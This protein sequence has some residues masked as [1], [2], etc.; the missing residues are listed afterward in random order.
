MCKRKKGPQYQISPKQQTL[1]QVYDKATKF[2]IDDKRQT[3][4][5]HLVAKMVCVDGQPLNL[6][7]NRG[8]KE[9]IEHLEPRFTMPTR[10]TL[11]NV[12]VP[13]MY[14]S[15]V[16]SVEVQLQDAEF[17]AVTT[18]LWTSVANT[19]FLSVTAHYVTKEFVLH[20]VC[21]EVIPF[22][23][24]SHTA[25]NISKFITSLL[26]KWG[27]LQKV[28]AIVRDNA[29]NLVAGLELSPFQHT[30]CLAHTLQL[31]L[32]EGFLNNKI[33]N[34]LVSSSKKIVGHFK[35]SARA[36]KV[37]KT[38]QITAGVVQHRLIHDEPT[39]WNTTLHMFKR[40][41]EQKKAIV[42]A[43][44]ELN[45]PELS[46][47]LWTLME[48]VIPILEVFDSVTTHISSDHVTVAE[49]IP[50]TNLIENELQKPA[51]A[52]SGLQGLKNDLLSS[53]K[54]RFKD[55]EN[56]QILTSA[57]L[58]DPRFKAAPFKDEAKC[59]AAKKKTVGGSIRSTNS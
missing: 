29:R 54:I 16:K 42:L 49:V 10:K 50:L 35:H 43:C 13:A 34:N 18:D 11:S 28:V 3:K 23:E 51:P 37:L 20:H 1:T 17:V 39:R 46:N 58:L 59:E 15:T 27:L 6:V 56:S 2:K 53:I 21:L 48:N 33:I 14:E 44:A 24:V 9:L 7:E 19:D 38:C 55:L 32:K 36:T 4:I 41:H 47:S 30:S 52:G 22:P 31:V 57:T 25:E 12:I 26:E 8:F 45:I 5:T 40:L